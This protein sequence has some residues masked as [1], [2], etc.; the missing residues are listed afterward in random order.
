MIIIYNPYNYGYIT[1]YNPH[2]TA[3]S[4]NDIKYQ[5]VKNEGTYNIHLL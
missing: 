5:I 3:P 1:L 2:G 4:S